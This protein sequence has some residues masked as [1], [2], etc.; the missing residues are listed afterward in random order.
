MNVTVLTPSC[1]WPRGSGLMNPNTPAAIRSVLDQNIE[2]LELWICFDGPQPKIRRFIEELNCSR[3]KVFETPP[4]SSSGNHQRRLLMEKLIDS[5]RG[6]I[7]AFHDDDDAY[8]PDGLKAMVELSSQHGEIPVL[9]RHSRP[10]LCELQTPESIDHATGRHFR[11][12][13]P[14]SF[15]ASVFPVIDDMPLWPTDGGYYADLP[16]ATKLVSWMEERGKKVI[17]L[18]AI[19]ARTRPLEIEGSKVPEYHL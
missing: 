17:L 11:F 15:A 8:L 13:V 10:I 4:T 12:K 6:G 9:A 5:K 19:V 18:E 2:N 1:D 7:F 14:I 3:I 16:Y